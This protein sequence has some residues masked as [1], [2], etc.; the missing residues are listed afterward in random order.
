MAPVTAAPGIGW[1]ND[2]FW[3]YFGTGR[4]FSKDDKSDRE[5]NYFFGVKEPLSNLAGDCGTPLMTW[6]VVG[7]LNAGLPEDTNP[8]NAMG[9]RGLLRSDYIQVLD[10]NSTSVNGKAIVFCEDDPFNTFNSGD[11]HLSEG[12]GLTKYTL[13][14]DSRE[15]FAFDELLKYV[16]GEHCYLNA[17]TSIGTDGWYRV[18]REARE[19]N[20][21]QS[22]LLG[23]LNTYTTYTP[24]DLICTAEGT[25]SLYG[26]HFQTG[27]AWY[28]NVFGTRR[29][30]NP[31]K[32][33][34]LDKYDLGQG[35]ATTP[36]LH[37]GLSSDADATAFIQTSTGE[38]VEVRQK[39]LPIRPMKPGRTNWS[40]I[41]E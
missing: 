30:D 21:G 6:G 36:S 33:V 11:C 41:C 7:W 2:N 39:R 35:L 27:T 38:I 25:S 34:I 23:G 12:L 13:V 22:T 17:D 37:V 15:Y 1:D 28:E 9:S 40:D 24:S 19:R 26:V 32:E 18:F 31:V 3:I 20:I 14:D 29:I 8:G 10:V 4:F 16:A 5:K